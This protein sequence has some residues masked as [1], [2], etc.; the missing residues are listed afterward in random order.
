MTTPTVVRVGLFALAIVALA[1]VPEVS[2]ANPVS[3]P[4]SGDVTVSGNGDLTVTSGPLQGKLMTFSFNATQKNGVVTGQATLD[5][6][7]TG[8]L[9][10]TEMAIDCLNF[11]PP[12]T[13][14]VSGTVTKGIPNRVGLTGVFKAEDNSKVSTRPPDSLSAPIAY[15]AHDPMYCQRGDFVTAP[16]RLTLYPLAHGTITVGLGTAAGKKGSDEADDDEDD[17]EKGEHE[18]D[19]QGKHQGKHNHKADDD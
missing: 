18:G 10:H 7:F 14:V 4:G 1:F 12:N 15:D 19:H 17:D 11:L 8:V 5:D 16:F 3:A 6:R 13:A 2:G 9:V